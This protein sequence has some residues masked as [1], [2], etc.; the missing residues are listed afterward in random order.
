MK[1]ALLLGASMLAVAAASTVSASAADM[2][3][4]EMG[5]YKDG[6]VYAAEHLDW[7]LLGG[8]TAA[9]LEQRDSCR[10]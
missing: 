6:P 3:R 7:L 2:Y 10:R 9:C 1:N 8:T 4:G 5:G